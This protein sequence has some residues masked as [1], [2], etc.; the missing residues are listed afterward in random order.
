MEGKGE[1]DEEADAFDGFGGGDGDVKWKNEMEAR[2]RS[3]RPQGFSPAAVGLTSVNITTG[4]Q[5]QIVLAMARRV[6]IR[7]ALHRR[8]DPL[9]NSAAHLDRLVDG[10]DGAAVAKRRHL[11]RRSH[12]MVY[13]RC[14]FKDAEEVVVTA[15]VPQ[16]P[17]SLFRDISGAGGAS[18]AK[19]G[20]G[21][22]DGGRQRR[23]TATRT[24]ALRVVLLGLPLRSEDQEVSMRQ[25]EGVGGGVGGGSDGTGNPSPNIGADG[26]D[27]AAALA[28]LMTPGGRAEKY[29]AAEVQADA[30]QVSDEPGHLHRSLRSF[31]RVAG[32][33][34]RL[35]LP[36]TDMPA[37]LRAW[38][39]RDAVGRPDLGLGESTLTRMMGSVLRP[40][41]T[42]LVVVLADGYLLGDAAGLE[43]LQMGHD[44]VS[45]APAP[46]EYIAPS[47]RP[48]YEP[49]D[50]AMP[51]GGAF[52]SGG[53][54]GGGGGGDGGVDG[55]GRIGAAASASFTR[56]SASVAASEGSFTSFPGSPI[57]AAPPVTPLTGHTPP[58]PYPGTPPGYSFALGGTQA[59]GYTEASGG[60]I[61]GR[62]GVGGAP[63]GVQVHRDGSVD[64]QM[65]RAGPLR[66]DGGRG[67]GEGGREK[68]N[69]PRGSGTRASERPGHANG[70]SGAPRSGGSARSM[71]RNNAS[72][73]GRRMNT[74]T[75]SGGGRTIPLR[76]TVASR[77]RDAEVAEQRSR[78]ASR[79]QVRVDARRRQA[80]TDAKGAPDSV[81]RGSFFGMSSQ[82]TVGAEGGGRGGGG[83]GDGGNRRQSDKRRRQ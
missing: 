26:V 19:W 66:Y 45:P 39:Q 42:T 30:L 46:R 63:M 62:A 74:S 82:Q 17:A 31:A 50:T 51:R 43:A 72:A 37:H 52:P 57:R 77:R 54:G 4:D 41:S 69:P 75:T 14:T 18:V 49:L 23:A 47:T 8:R 6:R 21:G 11:L 22:G 70:A 81:R 25:G 38:E 7:A 58:P 44:V 78:L 12:A 80:A 9:R 15:A 5:G 20:G 48:Q 76:P 71:A 13:L 3:S 10:V 60:S 55:G 34:R 28:R 1:G 67:G 2:K 79:D 56:P 68:G 83:G 40:P 27:K 64:I 61:G 29:A 53:G 65:G 36:E 32:T 59:K 24:V 73:G 16:N 33:L 35:P